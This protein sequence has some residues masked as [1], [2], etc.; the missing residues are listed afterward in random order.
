MDTPISQ[1]PSSHSA[2][3]MA[4]EDNDTSSVDVD[5]NMSL[6]RRVRL[7]EPRFLRS[8]TV[9]PD[10]H[11][12]QEFY[13]RPDLRSD[14]NYLSY[15]SQFMYTREEIQHDP[16]VLDVLLMMLHH[17]LRQ[18]TFNCCL[19]VLS[20]TSTSYS[21]YC[22]SYHLCLN[23]ER[24]LIRKPSMLLPKSSSHGPALTLAVSW[25]PQQASG[26]CLACQLGPN[27]L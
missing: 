26:T 23:S 22:N 19:T 11:E 5:E 12:S 13:D 1:S 17:A 2:F 16:E 21:R 15:R 9:T 14:H 18:T 3:R 20:Q 4:P 6:F 10:H 27:N 24:L 7:L 8:N 25:L